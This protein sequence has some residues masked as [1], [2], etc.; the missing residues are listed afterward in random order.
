MNKKKKKFDELE[1]RRAFVEKMDF[2][3]R[4]RNR[5]HFRTFWLN[6]VILSSAIV[7]GVL[8]IISGSSSPIQSPVLA[9]I[10]LLIIVVISVIIVIYFAGILTREK[11]LLFEQAQ[12]HEYI[13]SKQWRLLDEAIKKGKT[14]DEIT[15]IFDKSKR[16]SN[17]IEDEIVA[18]HLI[19]GNF[20][21]FRLFID[22]HFNHIISYGFVIGVLL[23]I[24]S[25]L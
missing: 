2:D 16:I 11:H 7:V 13:F 12:F 19:G 10:G 23:V 1:K 20:I 15:T 22:K 5:D 24:L 9:K 14:T 18:K 21:R 25:F 3:I 17:T 8:P 6:M 4:E